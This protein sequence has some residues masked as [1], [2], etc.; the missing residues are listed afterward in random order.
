MPNDRAVFF[1]NGPV[2]HDARLLREQAYVASGGQTGIIRP[3]SLEVTAQDTPDESVRIMPGTFSIAATA[4][5]GIGYTNA[6]GQSYSK[7]LYQPE[8]VQIR[9]TSSVGG[10]T[11]V[12]GIVI[13]DPEFEGTADDVD[14]ET[15][16]FWRVHVVENAGNNARLPQHFASLRRPFLPLAQVRLPPSTGTVQP[17]MI[18]DLRQMAISRT[19]PVGLYAVQ[20]GTF[21]LGTGDGTQEL[22][23]L[24]DV[25]V[26]SWATHAHISGSVSGIQA[27]GSGNFAGRLSSRLNSQS[28]RGF[29]TYFREAAT[30]SGTRIHLPLGASA[31]LTDSERGAVTDFQILVQRTSGPTSTLV[32]EDGWVRYTVNI[33]FSE[34]PIMRDPQ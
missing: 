8:T 27:Q 31:R 1:V 28:T 17:H 14:Y 19:Q 33:L 10:R 20:S 5:S 29:A 22:V 18:T 12:I 34:E 32:A 24:P 23:T 7:T 2:D 25:R 26:P 13:D 16:R 3:D 4:A 15:H 9:R 21:T 11:D 6:P 30:A